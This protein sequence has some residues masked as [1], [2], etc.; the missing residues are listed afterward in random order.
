MLLLLLAC[1]DPGDSTHKVEAGSP[2]ALDSGDSGAPDSGDSGAPDS[3]DSDSGDSGD[4]GTGDSGDSGTGD[5]GDSAEPWT[6]PERPD[7]D[8]PATTDDWRWGGGAGYP[9]TVDPDWPVVT[10]VSDLAGLSAALAVAVS[11]DVVWVEDD[12]EI[13][14]TGEALCIPAGVWLASDRGV[15]QGGLL[16]VTEGGDAVLETC[17]ED[18]RI[19]GLRLRGPDPDTCPPEWPSSCPNDV[20]GDSNC[21]YCTDTA[22]AIST[23]YD[24]LE[25]DNNELSGWTYAAVGVHGGLD[26]D[27]HHN[28]IHHDWREGLGYGVVI[29]GTAPTS[30]LVRWNRFNAIRHAVAG[31]GYPD[32]DYEARDNLVED[33][34]I[35][36]VFDMHGE[37]EVDRKSVV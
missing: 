20:S 16:Y 6:L 36:H 31:Q 14:L 27:V 13:D 15:G 32:E 21:A 23:T 26:A 5:S 30:A 17:G 8:S 37:D 7:V 1:A 33:D 22:Y 18:V 19:T 28:H 29:Y 9:D 34:A 35:G 4:S 2:H 10:R 25:V 12:A 24:R 11:G 3:G